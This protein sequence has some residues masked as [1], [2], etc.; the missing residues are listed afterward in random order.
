MRPR[1]KQKGPVTGKIM[2]VILLLSILHRDLNPTVGPIP[3]Y[4][5]VTIVH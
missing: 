1:S 2:V 5:D 4:L 3:S